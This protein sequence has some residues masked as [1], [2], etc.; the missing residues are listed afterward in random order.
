MSFCPLRPKFG[1]IWQSHDD[2]NTNSRRNFQI[3][4]PIC[5]FWISVIGH[6]KGHDLIFQR[7]PFELKFIDSFWSYGRKCNPQEKQNCHFA[8]ELTLFCMLL[9]KF[10]SLILSKFERFVGQIIAWSKGFDSENPKSSGFFAWNSATSSKLGNEFILMKEGWLWSNTS[11]AHLDKS[12]FKRNI[13]KDYSF[14]R[15]KIW[16]VNRKKVGFYRLL[17]I[18]KVKLGAEGQINRKIDHFCTPI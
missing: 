2:K 11:A 17:T 14:N 9:K 13:F 12:F 3:L 6:F 5:I 15:V 4:Q 16:N 18:S 8:S 10:R 1:R 7:R